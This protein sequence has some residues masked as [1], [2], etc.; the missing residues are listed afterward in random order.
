MAPKHSWFSDMAFGADNGEFRAVPYRSHQEAI[1][2]ARAALADPKGFG[3]IL[4][5]ASSGKTTIARALADQL[6]DDTA[7]ARL[8]GARMNGHSLLTEL[9][10]HFGYDADLDSSDELLRTVGMFAVR[11]LRKHQAPAVVIDNA[12]RMYPSAL[13]C[14]DGLA[15]LRVNNQFA[16]R[17]ILLG[18]NRLH[19]IVAVESLDHLARRL[20]VEFRLEPMSAQETMA[21]VH[22]HL[23]SCGVSPPDN[24]FPANVC[25]YLHSTSGGWPGLVNR[26]AID[27]LEHADRFPVTLA[28]LAGEN[29]AEPSSSDHDTIP[30]L[31]PEDDD[32]AASE[33][34]ETP[35]S[36]VAD[37]R[38]EKDAPAEPQEDREPPRLILTRDG[39]IV[40]DYTFN[41][42][43]VLIGRSELA[44]VIVPD[45]FVSK[46]HALLLL[47]SDALV[48]LDLNSANG[49]TV[50]STIV[51]ST[52]LNSGDIIV[53][54]NHRLKIENA[55]QVS[56]AIERVL[57]S[58][59]T[60]K[61]RTLIKSREYP[62][63][64]LRAVDS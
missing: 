58:G 36:A 12:D 64:P 10:G 62:L 57:A 26:R 55:P 47:Y 9:L 18:E 53:L 59:D 44:D 60:V 39:K 20:V 33:V 61:M 29:L 30:E 21:Y 5:P 16:L 45:A 25:E 24:V 51:R 7:V 38:R 2:A 13:R 8:D 1:A 11:Q 28:D 40:T 15:K 35:V 31:M 52:I 4:G 19:N 37:D 41:E 6:A 43:K 27:A 14:L 3:L 50:N 56:P 17:I 54:G 22:S 32:S 49:L 46:M 42:R 23:E 48:L 34:S 63:R